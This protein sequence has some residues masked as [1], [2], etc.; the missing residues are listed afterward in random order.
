DVYKRQVLVSLQRLGFD[1]IGHIIG[2]SPYEEPMG[3]M[4]HIGVAAGLFMVVVLVL[5]RMLER[6]GA[7]PLRAVLFLLLMLNSV[8]LGVTQNRAA[9]YA[10]L[11]SLLLFLATAPSWRRALLGAVVATA[12]FFGPNLLLG[13]P[14]YERGYTNMDTLKSRLV[15]WQFV[16]EVMSHIRGAP[17]L[18]G[19]SDAFL[20]ILTEHFSAERLLEFYRVEYKWPANAVVQQIESL[21]P[22]EKGRE[23]ILKVRFSQYGEQRDFQATYLVGLDKA[24][25]MFLD[26]MIAYGLFASLIWGFLLIYP[27]YL[28]W[29][30]KGLQDSLWLVLPAI[31]TYYMAWFPVVQLEPIFTLLIAAVWASA[32]ANRGRLS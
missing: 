1:P 17:L 21:P 15:M 2:G 6:E 3:S 24:H 31:G 7:I 27:V 25:N 11:L 9:V 28:L 18:G 30:R 20:L 22:L 4:G 5:L 8:G 14:P 10:L 26:R 16:P 29:K 32:E 19:G 13:P 12:I 23:R